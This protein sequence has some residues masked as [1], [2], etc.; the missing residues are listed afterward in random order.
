M[1]WFSG[2][3]LV[4]VLLT[5]CGTERAWTDH[6]VRDSA[7]VRIVENA[8]P[9]WD[10]GDEWKVSSPTLVMGGDDDDEGRL[11][12]VAGASRL[13]D[14][15]IVIANGGT[16]QLLFFAST[17]SFA[18]AAG[19]PGE[20]PGEFQAP[21]WL[22]RRV[23]DTLV[24][25]DRGTRRFSEFTSAGAHI[26]DTS[27]TLPD[28][29]TTWAIHGHVMDGRPLLARDVSFIPAVGEAGIQRQPLSAWLIAADGTLATEYGPFA[30]EAVF[31]RGGRQPGSLIRT[32]VPF[33]AAT[34][35]R[36]GAD[37]VVASDNGAYDVHTYDLS[38]RL[39]TIIRRGHER[40][41]VRAAD[42]AAYIEA[43]LSPLPPVAEIREGMRA[44]LEAVPAP[45]W[46]PAIRSMLVDTDAHLWVEAGRWMDERTATW[47]VFD[48][49]GV[50]L[51]DVALPAAYEP[52]EIGRDYIL[53]LVR[54]TLDVESVVMLPLE[55]RGGVSHL[56]PDGGD[57]RP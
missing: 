6:V 3:A 12:R 43:R 44:S 21:A 36:A 15:T 51:G 24:V 34:I 54:D 23:G 35:L 39:V 28:G 25:W 17:G 57:S 27:P 30:G 40:Q 55:R 32:P 49:T 19:G 5:A 46:M 47:S 45:E 56:D 41:P 1:K 33:G 22:G 42:I 2:R 37:R 38:G 16:A 14:G 26:A 20:G 50:W 4:L 7:G 48:R 13:S 29:P 9:A 53:A 8:R 52:L 11:H 31:L 18:R 10:A